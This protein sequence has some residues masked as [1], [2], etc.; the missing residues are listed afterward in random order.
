MERS[1]AEKLIRQI[2]DRIDQIA[3]EYGVESD[4]FKILT[5]HTRG[6]DAP[7]MV[8][9][10]AGAPHVRSTKANRGDLQMLERIREDL[11][12]KSEIKKSASAAGVSEAIF[13]KEYERAAANIESR[14]QEIYGR[15][16]TRTDEM[17]KD[18]KKQM[19]VLHKD[20]NTK[21]ELVKAFRVL[22]KYYDGEE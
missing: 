13:A 7:E 21:A 5:K 3:R 19:E 4:I 6:G 12:T 16:G 17:P 9:S 22:D 2:N 8:T 1:E 20:F 11:S 18:L 15:Y 10:K 14:L